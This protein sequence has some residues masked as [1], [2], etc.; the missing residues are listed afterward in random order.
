MQIINKYIAKSF[1]TT[2][3]IALTLFV[4]I[5]SI[6]N[7]FKLIDFFARG[8]S[9]IIILQ[10][11]SYGMPFFLIFA[12][13][14]S[15]LG[16]SYLVYSRM[17]ADL[18]IVAMKACGI[19]MWQAIRTPIMLS[20]L[21]TV[22]CVYINSEIAPRSH[23]AR[24]EVAQALKM[25][26]E[27]PLNLLQ[28][29]VFNDEIPGLTI[30][31]GKKND[32]NIEDIIIYEYSEAGARRTIRAET[33]TVSVDDTEGNVIT[34]DLFDVK[35]DIAHEDDPSD[36]SR[37]K[38][39]TAGHYPIV[40]D[41]DELMRCGIVWKKKA[42]LTLLELIEGLRTNVNNVMPGVLPENEQMVRSSFLVEINTRMALSMSC[43]V[44][45]LLGSSLGIKI[46]RKESMVG[47]GL[48]LILVFSFYF[49]VMIADTLVTKPE[50][51]PY[52]IVWLPVLISSLIGTMLI[53][54]N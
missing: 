20:I 37:A 33:G 21:L 25:D 14:I 38:H 50:M 10:I 51:R 27:T 41:V 30:Y 34:I 13:P 9:G 35:I 2:F 44:F 11:F 24:R 17:A 39:I 5:L 40:L 29:G 26:V 1:L 4:F 3:V 31:I 8:V 45:V 19:S 16:A 48:T 32:K 46:H 54:R 18:E 52:L 15:V 36:L 28:E 43:F 6:A 47:L 49:F 12:I 53:N 22:A 7:F 23:L 42:D